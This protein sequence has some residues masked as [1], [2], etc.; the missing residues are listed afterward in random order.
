LPQV[1]GDPYLVQRAVSNLVSNAIRHTPPG[2]DIRVVTRQVKDHVEV[3]VSD[4]GVGIAA[5]HLPHIFERFYRADASRDRHSGGRGLGLA[6]V[7][8]IMEQH[9][10]DVRVEST[11][12]K[13]STFTLAWSSAPKASG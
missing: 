5:E 11:P 2:G 1:Y 13:G 9:S 3:A 4:S 7:K 8:Q 10:G 12:G 6:I